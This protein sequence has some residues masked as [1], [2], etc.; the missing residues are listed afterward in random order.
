MTPNGVG[1]QSVLART[2]FGFL[3]FLCAAHAAAAR[4]HVLAVGSS[5]VFPFAT[6][7]A[8]RVARTTGLKSPQVEAWGTGGGI[9]LFCRGIGVSEPDVALASREI[10]ADELARCGADGVGKILKLRFGSDGITIVTPKTLSLSL[11]LRNIYLA[12]ARKVPDPNAVGVL[13]DNPYRRWSEVDTRLP[14]VP[15]LVY[16]PPLT[17][18]TRD[19]LVQLGL[20]RGCRTVS[21]LK[22]LEGTDPGRFREAC[23]AIREDGAYVTVGENDNL[24]VRKVAM[25]DSAAGVF[26]FSYYEHNRDLLQAAEIEGVAPSFETIFQGTYPLARPLY[27][28]AKLAHMRRIPGLLPFLEEFTSAQAVGEDG[29]LI[30]H[31]LVPIPESERVTNARLLEEARRE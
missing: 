18:G 4:D 20:E 27:I 25:S 26:G 1:S 8:E 30:D 3:A 24:I 21:W 11:T 17:S 9:K 14:D 10:T 15:I 2:I 7:V 23:G 6:A 5:T 22:E 16:G 19:L 12:L 28:Y 29:Y 31:G 13:V